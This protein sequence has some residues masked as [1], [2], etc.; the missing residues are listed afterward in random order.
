M[1]LKTLDKQKLNQVDLGANIG[2]LKII[3]L[4]Y[5]HV[6]IGLASSSANNERK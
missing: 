5:M 6:H 4:Q 2:N 1:H 3:H